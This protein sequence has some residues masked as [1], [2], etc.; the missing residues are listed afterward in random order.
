M[1]TRAPY[2]VVG[3][4]VIMLLGALVA[5]VLWIARV[6]FNQEFAYYDIYFGASITGLTQ[7]STVRYNGI[8]VGRVAEVKLDPQDP[9]RVRVTVELQGGT[10]VK[11]DVVA[12]L[13]LQ[14]LT[15]GAFV[16]LTG[17]SRESPPLERLP[18]NRYPV[19]ASRPSTLQKVVASAPEAMARLI[20]LADRLNAMLDEQNR[21]A[22]AETLDNLRKVTGGV[23]NQATQIDAAIADGAAALHDLH[24]T[25][26]AANGI[27]A[28]LQKLTAPGGEAPATLKTVNDAARDFDGLAK[29]L[30]A[31]VAENQPQVKDFTRQGFDQ[32]AQLVAQAQQLVAQLSRIADGIER[33]PTRL[34]YGD[35]REGYQP[36]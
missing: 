5:A 1:E 11:S 35:R 20:T 15:G 4:V 36:R 10:E 16:N 21:Q 18:G 6:Q 9:T 2:V 32:L 33:D 17:G 26:D 7:G 3:I 29:R 34:L 12:E 31:L 22:F 19:I 13:E 28:Q 30:D 24:T 25:V 23:A 27:L 14:G 8:P